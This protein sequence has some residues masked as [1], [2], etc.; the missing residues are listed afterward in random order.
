MTIFKRE[1]GVRIRRGEQSLW[2]PSRN[3]ICKCPRVR[4]GKSYL[5]LGRDD[6]TDANR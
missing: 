4:L 6:T 5:I 1:A 2:V 3:F